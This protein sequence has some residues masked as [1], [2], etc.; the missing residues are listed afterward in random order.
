[1]AE[2]EPSLTEEQRE[3]ARFPADAKTIVLAGAGTGKTRLLAAR[4]VDLIDRQDLG[5]A[6]VLVLSFS[7]AAVSEIRKRVAL[8][9]GTRGVSPA[10]FD[11]FATNVL[12]SFDPSGEWH[13]QG[14]ERRIETATRLLQVNEEARARVSDLQHVLIDEAQDL[15]GVR[16]RLVMELLETV[17]GGATLFGD[18]AQSI[19]GFS[20]DGAREGEGIL[21]LIRRRFPDRFMERRLS[22]NFR[23][24]SAVTK[25]VLPFGERLQVSIPDYTGIRRD[26]E[27][28]ILGLPVI[29]ELAHAG[30]MLRRRDGR[31]TAILCRTNGEVLAISRLCFKLNVEHQVQRRASDRVAPPWIAAVVAGVEA[32]RIG[33]RH[34]MERLE[35]ITGR[36]ALSADEMWRQV[37]LL[38][39]GASDNVDLRAIATRIRDGTFPEELNAVPREPV[40]VSSIHRAKGLEFDRVVV[41]EPGPH[42][43][44]TA[45]EGEEVRVL[46][47][48][49]TR[50][51]SELY[52]LRRLDMGGLRFIPRIGRWTRQ[53]Y[54][55]KARRISAFEVVGS[56]VDGS[57]PPGA[58]G[59]RSCDVSE[60]QRYIRSRIEP[61]DPVDI[62]VLR[63]GRD[64][65]K[66]FGIQHDGQ[67]VGMMSR[68]FCEL[69]GRALGERR[70]VWPRRIGGL[71]VEC[72]DTVAGDEIAGAAH[73]LGA[74]GMWC[75]VRVHGLGDLEY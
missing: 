74:S 28:F 60:T 66:D 19:Y 59:V 12:G 58:V 33:R 51:I 62:V 39:R 4:L 1:V 48:A 47:V 14:Y 8:G 23:A 54:R 36:Y 40:T 57:E 5:P 61:G 30:P 34:L 69:L 46:Y 52:M 18:P 32:V 45:G 35:C 55:G 16:A 26:L 68:M 37:R 44:E 63:E 20:E 42:G 21:D 9:G 22:R 7:R 64:A 38:D 43:A 11:S 6:D 67:L 13:D 71:R 17:R 73:A 31:T 50:A 2:A 72:V 29:T 27:S 15:V 41:L 75:R 70:T 25:S 3:I 56:D 49:L 53:E 24:V 65:G 10:T